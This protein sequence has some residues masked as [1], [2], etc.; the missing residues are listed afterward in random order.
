MLQ[1]RTN[2]LMTRMCDAM[3]ELSRKSGLAAN[4]AAHT[5]VNFTK[6]RHVG[7]LLTY[8]DLQICS[9]S[10]SCHSVCCYNVGACAEQGEGV[11]D[12]HYE[13]VVMKV[14]GKEDISLAKANWELYTTMVAMVSHCACAC[15]LWLVVC[16]N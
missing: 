6:T 16:Y 1:Q 11:T 7:Y 12:Q 14:Q 2:R 10:P 9:H 3:Q 5:S 15:T 4:S 13:Q 8:A